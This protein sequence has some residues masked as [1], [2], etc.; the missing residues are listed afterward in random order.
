M[1]AGSDLSQYRL[2]GGA[3]RSGGDRRDGADVHQIDHRDRCVGF[4]KRRGDGREAARSETR[5]AEFGRQHQPEQPG[6]PE[7]VDSLGREPAL[8]GPAADR[9]QGGARRLHTPAQQKE[10]TR[11]RAQGLRCRN[12]R[13]ATTVAYPPC[14]AR[15]APPDPCALFRAAQGTKVTQPGWVR[16]DAMYGAYSSWINDGEKYALVGLSVKTEGSIPSG[17]ISANL[18]TLVDTSFKISVELARVAW[19]HTR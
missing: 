4:S 11:R 5:P 3:R 12:W 8:L 10:A 13:T 2:D 17:K 9:A 14:A 19:Q 7:R 15:P 6:P 1:P 18:W 16:N